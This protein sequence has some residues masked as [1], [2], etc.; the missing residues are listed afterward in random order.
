MQ[1]S[2]VIHLL[3]SSF[4]SSSSLQFLNDNSS[5]SSGHQHQ[6]NKHAMTD[7]L[8]T[9]VVSLAHV[10]LIVQGKIHEFQTEQYLIQIDGPWTPPDSSSSMMISS[11][12]SSSSSSMN[13]SNNANANKSL[14]ASINNNDGCVVVMK[15]RK[16]GQGPNNGTNHG[17]QKLLSKKFQMPSRYVPTRE[18]VSSRGKDGETLWRDGRR[19][20]PLQPGEYLKQFQNEGNGNPCYDYENSR[21]KI[22]EERS[23]GGHHATDHGRVIIGSGAHETI[24]TGGGHFRHPLDNSKTQQPHG[25]PFVTNDYNPDAFYGSDNDDE[26]DHDDDGNDMESYNTKTKSNDIPNKKQHHLGQQMYFANDMIAKDYVNYKGTSQEAVS[27]SDCLSELAPESTQRNEG[28]AISQVD[29]LKLF[30]FESRTVDQKEINQDRGGQQES[31]NGQEY[32]KDQGHDMY[33]MGCPKG[34]NVGTTCNSFLEGLKRNDQRLDQD[35]FQIRNGD[36]NDDEIRYHGVSKDVLTGMDSKNSVDGDDDDGDDDDGEDD[37]LPWN[38]FLPHGTKEDCTID[39]I[40][41]GDKDSDL[42]EQGHGHR[43]GHREDDDGSDHDDAPVSFNIHVADDDSDSSS[44]EE[45]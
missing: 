5:S 30:N 15:K 28:D 45:D 34:D 19:R 4:P 18:D 27:T 12:E 6:D 42:M 36:W 44:E 35:P 24:Q 7:I 16:V 13:C 25:N 43:N 41:D 32:E 26:N 1:T 9:L 40:S 14:N 20:R 29:L 2:G 22:H 39:R 17:M 33:G 3:C 21:S 10:D 11:S 31:N 23:L 37:D 38:A 8:D